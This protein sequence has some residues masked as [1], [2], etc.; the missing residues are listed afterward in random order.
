[1][2][3]ALLQC[4]LAAI[5]LTPGNGFLSA[6]APPAPPDAELAAHAADYTFGYYPYGWRG[7]DPKGDIV[8][9]DEAPMDQINPF[10]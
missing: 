3:N 5:L 10:G 4:L 7:R 6:Q 2:K 1:M 9:L 8:F